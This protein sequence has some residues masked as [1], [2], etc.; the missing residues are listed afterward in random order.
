MPK[1]E[2]LM[3]TKKIKGRKRHIVVYTLGNIIDLQVHDAN[4]HDSK[5]ARLFLTSLKTFISIGKDYC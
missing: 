3:E 1:Q 5:G 4:I 2:V